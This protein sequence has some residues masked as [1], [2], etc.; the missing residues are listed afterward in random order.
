MKFHDLAR[1]P[2]L[3]AQVFL[4]HRCSDHK[5]SNYL[6]HKLKNVFSI[7]YSCSPIGSMQI[8]DLLVPRNELLRSDFVLFLASNESLST[9]S[10]SSAELNIATILKIRAEKRLGLI[11]LNDFKIPDVFSEY[12]FG[13]FNWLTRSQDAD[14][15]SSDIVQTLKSDFSFDFQS[16]GHLCPSW[17][18]GKS[19]NPILE[20][21]RDGKIEERTVLPLSVPMR[22]ATMTQLIEAIKI[23]PEDKLSNSISFLSQIFEDSSRYSAV[24]RQNAIFILGKICKRDIGFL[25]KL[26]LNYPDFDNPFLFRGFH[27]ALSYGLDGIMP[28]YINALES[29]SRKEWKTQRILNKEFHFRYYGGIPGTL[30]ELRTSIVQGRPRCLLRLNVFTLGEISTFRSDKKLLQENRPHLEMF[31]VPSSTI[32]RAIKKIEKNLDKTIF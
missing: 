16:V 25:R 5:Y 19:L 2:Y 3:S 30:H 22:H 21:I 10:I 26:K 27:I 24:A 7:W 23:L 28:Q 20:F 1:S 18:A 32:D 14:R 6:Y 8:G 13:R 12:K 4:A 17:I 15:I 9:R 31:G 11:A 29:E